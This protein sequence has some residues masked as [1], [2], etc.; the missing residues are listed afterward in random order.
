MARNWLAFDCFLRRR[1]ETMNSNPYLP[2]TGF[3]AV[4]LPMG[5]LAVWPAVADEDGDAVKN[6]ALH[7][8]SVLQTTLEADDLIKLFSRTVK[9]HI[10]HDGIHYE[11]AV[12]GLDT[13]LG[14]RAGHECTYELTLGGTQLGRLSL[15]RRR[16]F[17][18]EETALLDALVWF[19]VYPL[20]NAL[21]YRRAMRTAYHDPLTGAKN[22]GAFDEDLIHEVERA[23]RNGQPLSLVVVDI[24]HFKAINDNFGHA[25]GDCAL[26]SLVE[27][28]AECIRGSDALYRYGGE[29][30][31]LILGDTD[32]VG[33]RR[34]AERLRRDV[35][36]RE[37]LCGE[38]R[39]SMTL[40]LGVAELRPGEDGRA[41]FK[42][43]D[44]ALYRAK[45][46]GRNR[47]ELD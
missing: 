16:G 42:R 34:L 9:G 45:Q 44:A 15:Y 19:L 38:T 22:R 11:Y 18:G 8:L 20:R 47:V 41:L 3:V 46:T 29:E 32:L 17:A 39:L 2:P 1:A 12:E 4:D 21:L 43:A 10:P 40:S 33:A 14:I 24:D 36:L 26:Q 37:H 13:G 5:N 30:F 35:E 25:I 23:R 31:V 6:R 7:I 28:G 27:C